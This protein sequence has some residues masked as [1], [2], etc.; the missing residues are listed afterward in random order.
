MPTTLRHSAP[1]PGS[2]RPALYVE[3]LEDRATPC[4]SITDLGTLGGTSSQAFA[5]NNVG[6]VVGYA[7]TA[8]DEAAHAFVYDNGTMIDLGTLG[9]P[10]SAA[11]AINDSGLVAGSASVPGT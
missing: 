10:S 9:G 11:V 5:L 1:R 3:L 4:Y 6:Q 8:R 7:Q 2:R